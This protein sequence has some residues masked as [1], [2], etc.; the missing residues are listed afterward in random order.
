M[1]E[2]D[3]VLMQDSLA[4]CKK[5]DLI[6]NSKQQKNISYRLLVGQIGGG[7]WKFTDYK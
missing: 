5:K 6:Y 7:C 1:L 2:S 3:S 4:L